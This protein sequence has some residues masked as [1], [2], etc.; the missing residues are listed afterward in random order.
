MAASQI[1]NLID[2]RRSKGFFKNAEARSYDAE[3]GWHYLPQTFVPK[4]A[5][6][7]SSKVEQDSK[8]LRMLELHASRTFENPLVEQRTRWLLFSWALRNA[9]TSN[10]KR[11]FDLAVSLG[12]LFMVLP[13]MVITAIAI[14]LD[15]P[16]PVIF[17]QIRV[18]RRGQFFSCYKF[19]SMYIDAEERKAELMDQ[20]EADEIV[21]KM[22]R[23]PRVT[24]VG[25]IIRKLSIDEL[26]QIFN[27]IK[28]E[29]SLIGPRPPV[30]IE[31]EYYQYEHFRRLD[32][33]PGITGLQQ[34]SGRSDITFKRWVAL[35]IAYID[36]QSMKKDIEILLKTIPA[37]I[38]GKGAY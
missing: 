37:V 25:R 33:V 32:S 8:A 19:R 9:I 38:S 17:K 14:K 15:S 24:R 5:D 3:T 1:S 2:K 4:V 10:L 18:G 6:L 27:V 29:M 34:V 13:I 12:G 16:G 35:D 31:V 36:E 28:G 21:F 11:I 20:N 23:D 7:V 26:P 22:K 30:P